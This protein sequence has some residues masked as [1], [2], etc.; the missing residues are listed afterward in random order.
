MV[1]A[2]PNIGAN[3]ELPELY[4]KLSGHNAVVVVQEGKAIGVLTKMGVITHLSKRA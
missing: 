2:L 1:A 3:A 4:M